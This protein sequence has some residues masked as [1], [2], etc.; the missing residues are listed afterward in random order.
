METSALLAALLEQDSA[1]KRALRT[2]DRRV[3]SRLTLTEAERA[4]V[5][6]RVSGRLDPD[7][8]RQGIRALRTFSS[9]CDLVAVTADVLTR[10]A[11]PFPVEPIRTLDAIHLAT[12][13]LLGEPPALLTVLTRDNRIRDNARAL[14]Y[15]VA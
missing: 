4:L 3:T 1:A 13:E 6:A 10:A 11:R 15:G 12:V 8:Q 7:H 5:R 9:R 2:T 14:G